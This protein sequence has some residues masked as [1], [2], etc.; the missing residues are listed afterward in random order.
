MKIFLYLFRQTFISYIAVASLLLIIIISG[1]FVSY[2]ADA[3]TGRF[4]SD[5]VLSLILFKLPSFASIIFPVGLFIAILLSYGQLY[6]DSEMVVIKACGI[7]K[8]KLLSY[9]MGPASFVMLLVGTL[10]LYLAPLG[11]QYFMAA[12][13]NPDNFSGLGTLLPGKFES[14]GS[15][16]TIYMGSISTDKTQAKDV[17]LLRTADDGTVNLIRADYGTIIGKNAFEKNL[18]LKQGSLLTGQLNSAALTFSDFDEL[19]YRIEDKNRDDF[20]SGSVEDVEALSTLALLENP[21][22]VNLVELLWRV[23]LILLVPISSLIALSMSETSSRKGRYAKL[24][25][26]I[27]IFITYL[28]LM[29]LAKNEG[30]KGEIFEGVIL[31]PHLIFLGL[32]LVLYFWFECKVFLTS[33]KIKASA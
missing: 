5:L 13:Q 26:A 3:A 28:G 20:L 6:V 11:N 16:N 24:L 32:G 10:T 29:I 22:G 27:L 25:P 4:S 14:I 12:W 18:S 9:I 17:F 21:Q 15:N 30:V 31:L 7:S 23:S 33:K 2:L 19:D 8:K 1:R